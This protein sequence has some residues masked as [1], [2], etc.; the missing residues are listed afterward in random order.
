MSTSTQLA[1]YLA[2]L[3]KQAPSGTGAF[4][5]GQLGLPSPYPPYLDV[6]SPVFG[7]KGDSS[8]ATD[9][10]VAINLALT[11]AYDSGGQINGIYIPDPPAQ[12]GG[13]RGFYNCKNPLLLYN[14]SRVIGA[15]YRTTVLQFTDCHGFSPADTT[16]L[17]ADV[18]LENLTLLGNAPTSS[19][20]TATIGINAKG[21]NHWCLR[22]L[23]VQE[24]V[25]QFVFDAGTTGGAFAHC[26][27]LESYNI[28]FPNATNGYPRY[29]MRLTGSSGTTQCVEV[30]G[31]TL[32]GNLSAKTHTYT[33][34]GVT[35]TF[36]LQPNAPL[37]AE[38]GIKVYFIGGD[39]YT[40]KK[41]SAGG[42]PD[43]RLYDFTTGSNVLIPNGS[44]GSGS[45]NVNVIFT[46]APAN[47]Q[48]IIICYNDPYAFK[49]VYIDKGTANRIMLAQIQGCQIAVDDESGHNWVDVSNL[50]ILN[51]AWEANGQG[52]RMT[53]SNYEG[54]SVIDN[55]YTSSTGSLTTL[56]TGAGWDWTEVSATNATTGDQTFTSPSFNTVL[57]DNSPRGTLLFQEFG[58]CTREI[59]VQFVAALTNS[60][61]G[62][63]QAQFQL[64]VSYD[65][66]STWSTMTNGKFDVSGYTSASSTFYQ[67]V[68][69]TFRDTSSLGLPINNEPLKIGYRLQIAIVSGTNCTIDTAGGSQAYFLR[70][71]N[72]NRVG[73]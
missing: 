20:A 38:S 14:S 43:Y 41:S 12:S 58:A 30:F 53:V 59:E 45:Q 22:N 4:L 70:A 27:N 67:P 49:G 34:D 2:W 69:M 8:A 17:C 62:A 28:Q 23:I 51:T 32:S 50:E 26:F 25:D 68:R 60:S 7:A 52:S 1:E 37:W 33:G 10:S 54:G 72:V 47:G 9:D 18:H 44:T 61:G 11:T 57:T 55:I 42:S 40:V 65:G 39:N 3:N 48:S 73:A 71:R 5:G 19:S 64:Q 21:F 35:T 56:E 6:T 36:N 63:V 15:G 46:V 13:A 31:G 24:F 29:L 16:K 66:T